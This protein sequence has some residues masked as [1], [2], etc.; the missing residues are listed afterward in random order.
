V[1]GV[2][3]GGNRARRSWLSGWLSGWLSARG[4]LVNEAVEVERVSGGG[5]PFFVFVL[6]HAGD[7]R[8]RSAELRGL[9]ALSMRDQRPAA[10]EKRTTTTDAERKKLLCVVVAI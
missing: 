1:V 4:V 8:A 5:G 2:G 6:T 7:K 9:C 3:E 10:A